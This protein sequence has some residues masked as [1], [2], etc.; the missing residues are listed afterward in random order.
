MTATS[1]TF[2]QRRWAASELRKLSPEQR[3]AILQAAAAKAEA[4]YQRNA[5]LTDFD[6]FG[7]EDLHG[8]SAN[9]EAR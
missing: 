8:G 9:T 2:L 4:E 6:A 1:E 7:P 3:D 5:E